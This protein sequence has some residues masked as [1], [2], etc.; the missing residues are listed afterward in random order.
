MTKI[1][2]HLKRFEQLSVHEL[3]DVLKLRQQVFV[4]EQNC[5]YPDIDD[6]DKTAWHLLGY[7]GELLTAYSRI[8]QTEGDSYF[9]A[10]GRIVTDQTV[11]GLGVGKALM[12]ESLNGVQ[13]KFPR[14]MV[15]IS[16][17]AHLE[18]F[19]AEFGFVK[20]SDPYDEDGILHIDMQFTNI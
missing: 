14:R 4:I 8:Y 9:A 1:I 17:Q 6:T 12:T 19:Y 2:W 18:D 11:R 15:K 7:Q 10:I 3:F 16:A 20:T 5:V 13:S